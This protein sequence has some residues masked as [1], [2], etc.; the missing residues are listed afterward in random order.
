M[1]ITKEVI[2][3]MELINENAVY[4]VTP[5]KGQSSLAYKE[6]LVIIRQLE[7]AG[8]V[9]CFGRCRRD[10][11]LTQKGLDLYNENKERLN[12]A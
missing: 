1:Q 7:L 2:Q 12:N 10:Y 6:N 3:V 5:E 4:R 9:G 8:I 11:F